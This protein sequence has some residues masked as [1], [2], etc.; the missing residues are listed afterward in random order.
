MSV[1]TEL[2][3]VRE[4]KKVRRL[5]AECRAKGENEDML[6]SAQQALSWMLRRGMS[7]TELEETIIAVAAEFED[8]DHG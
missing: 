6:Y 5:L 1:R 3:V 7:P 4:L 2:E 8:L